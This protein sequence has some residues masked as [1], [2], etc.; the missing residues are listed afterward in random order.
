ML[1]NSCFAQ[2]LDNSVGNAL[3]DHWRFNNTFIKKNSICEIRVEHSIKPDG[4]GISKTGDVSIFQ[5]D[6]STG[7]KREHVKISS[8]FGRSDTT[9]IRYRYMDEKLM[10]TT[11]TN[12]RS[13][14]TDT[15]IYSDSAT[16][17]TRFKADI[18]G[19]L[20]KTQVRSET[21]NTS[22]PNDTTKI[23]LSRNDI[24]LPYFK[25]TWTWDSQ[26]FLVGME[27]EFI[28]SAEKKQIRYAYDKYARISERMTHENGKIT[29]E[30]F[31][32]DTWGNL[33]KLRRYEGEILVHSQE[34]LLS[35]N[36]LPEA[37]LTRLEKSDEIVISKLFYSYCE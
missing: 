24:G 18:N 26:G 2:L 20:R 5:F 35:A 15:L 31:S 28:I 1:V 16:T 11:Q 36:G 17:A 3:E 29:K 22:W 33:E 37:I 7:K 23:V 32:Y 14:I 21:K 27:S 10:S 12:A 30:T 19:Q 9:N 25:E 6:Q 13:V 8:L 34:L 4:M